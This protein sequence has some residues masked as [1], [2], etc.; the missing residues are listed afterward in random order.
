MSMEQLGAAM[1]E[2]CPLCGGVPVCVACG[3]DRDCHDHFHAEAIKR[4]NPILVES[5]GE[6][7]Q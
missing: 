3:L 1:T 4:A 7:S 6:E 2:R 5:G